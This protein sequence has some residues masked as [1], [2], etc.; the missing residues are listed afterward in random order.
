MPK[1]KKFY[2][3]ALFLFI[4]SVL[5]FAIKTYLS[6]NQKEKCIKTLT[7]SAQISVDFNQSTIILSGSISADRHEVVVQLIEE[8]CRNLTIQNNIKINAKSK[9]SESW[10]NFKIDHVN[11]KIT[12]LGIVNNQGDIDSIL[13]SFSESLPNMS[14]EY[15]I[16]LDKHV[17]DKNFAVTTMLI[18]TVIDEIKLIDINLY[19]QDLIIKGLVRDKLREQQALIKLNQIFENELNIINQLELVIN[20]KPEIDK[21]EFEKILLP[22]LKH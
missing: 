11:Q 10:L 17:K 9:F 19:K 5:F 20:N 12:I 4:A 13:K 7:Q 21:L 16:D 1:N 2:I 6:N 14:I 18:L 3:L 15:E 22:E 8:Q